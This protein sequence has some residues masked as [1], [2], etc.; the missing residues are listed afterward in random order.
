M[1]QK[2]EF[3]E[4]ELKGA[5]LIKPFFSDDNRGGFIKDYNI[6]IFKNEFLKGCSLKDMELMIDLIEEEKE[7]RATKKWEIIRKKLIDTL[8]SFE[9]RYNVTV[10][11]AIDSY[12]GTLIDLINKDCYLDE[13][14]EG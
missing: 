13:L 8:I 14:E 5:F 4:L 11:Y 1:I 2:F 3:Q 9:E 10:G 6:D 12:D 7:E